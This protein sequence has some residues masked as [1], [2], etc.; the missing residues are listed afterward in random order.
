[1]AESLS[2]AFESMRDFVV[3][4]WGS[5]ADNP[6]WVSLWKTAATPQGASLVAT[7]IAA[8]GVGL[9]VGRL[10]TRPRPEAPATAPEPDQRPVDRLLGE[11]SVD[12]PPTSEPPLTDPEMEAPLRPDAA[13]AA[14]R[15]ALAERGFADAAIDVRVDTFAAGLAETGVA[16]KAL[17]AEDAETAPL[18]RAARH[19]LDGGDLEGAIRNLDL[20]RGRLGASSRPLANRA[21]GLRHA[22][23]AAAGL[24]GDLEM[25]RCDYAAA[26]RLFGR[27]CELLGRG[28]G[29]R[30]VPLLT[31]RATAAFRAG[32][33]RDADTL[34]QRA[35]VIAEQ[36]YG[37][38]HPETAKAVSRLGFV[39][40]ATG[41]VDDAE[42]L[43]RRALATDEKALGPEHPDLA[44]DLNNLAQL[45]IRQE[46]RAAAEP[47]LRRAL[48]I[49]QKTQGAGHADTVRAV[50]AFADFLRQTDRAQE[51]NR[52]LATVAVARREAERAAE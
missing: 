2:Q 32:A 1:M 42:R 39:R 45:K 51:A 31:K 46:D 21:A 15:A 38:D 34:L 6:A 19:A 5:V 18:V 37:R 52:L 47:L 29:E 24:A 11:P 41:K 35:V 22:A 44:V 17:L 7:V 9:V 26:A 33:A 50:R 27:A 48:A 13:A 10:W 40:F 43:Y 4:L 16:L 14:L 12:E 8:F 25:S 23:A 36:V 20:A 49:R 3:G 30:L 28:E